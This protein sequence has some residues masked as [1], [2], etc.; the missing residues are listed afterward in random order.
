MSDEVKHVL[1][2][3]RS[4]VWHPYA[5]AHVGV[6]YVVQGARGCSLSLTD[7]QDVTHE[8]VDAMA[9][10]WCMIHGYRNPHLDQ[11]ITNQVDTFAHV[12]FGG[13]THKPAVDLA[14][15]LLRLCPDGMSRVFLADSGSVS[16]EVALKAAL[17]A[18]AG[19]G[20][21]GAHKFL[22][23]RG[24]YHGDTLGAMS[25]CDPVGGMHSS[26]A[27][28]LPRN[29]FVP[30]PPL[31]HHNGVV[32]DFHQ[33]VPD[34]AG[35]ERDVTALIHEH[36]DQL[37]GVIVEPLVQGA[38]GMYPYPARCLKVLR[39]L[40]DEIGAV[41]IF[42]EIATGFGRLGQMFAADLAGVTPDIMCVGKALTGGY[43]TLAAMVCTQ[44]VA[45][46]VDASPAGALL[47]GP[48]F[49]GNP[50]AC[51]VALASLALLQTPD[52]AANLHR[53]HQHLAQHLTGVT[54][55]AGVRRV[56][57]AG[58]IAAVQATADIDI[59]H[60]TQRGVELGVWFRPFRDLLYTMPP[61]VMS[62]EDLL[63]VTSAIRSLSE[64]VLS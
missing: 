33:P 47:H 24:G 48:T 9:S 40:C 64:N 63:T 38:G 14:D 49:M 59:A 46:D 22:S 53:V 54:D 6:P 2:R 41:L 29:V 13:L 3:D 4:S 27:G 1:D 62:D 37:A 50:L 32:V 15:E 36:A 34:L 16:V 12:M 23:L 43:M 11:A 61:H 56:S 60:V 44:A 42:D 5:P 52:T 58:T 21:H 55:Q 45:S 35:W 30:R 39:D 8:V 26:F 7:H 20:R 31:A 18:A 57:V 28:V 25:V 19:R 10:W 51:R 17:Q